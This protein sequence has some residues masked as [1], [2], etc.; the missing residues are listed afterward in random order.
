V[1]LPALKVGLPGKVVSFTGCPLTR[2]KGRGLRALAGQIRYRLTLKPLSCP[3]RPISPKPIK[4][5]VEGSGT[6]SGSVADV[7]R[8][9][10]LFELVDT[11][12][13]FEPKIRIDGNGFHQ[14]SRGRQHQYIVLSTDPARR[15]WH[16]FKAGSWLPE[17]SQAMISRSVFVL[18][19]R[20]KLKIRSVNQ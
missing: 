4:R 12:Q 14:I 16:V 9:L 19:V 3:Q 17:L 5:M 8:N 7:R 13:R 15:R 11:P 20:F 18:G 10:S 6:L 2:P 1:K